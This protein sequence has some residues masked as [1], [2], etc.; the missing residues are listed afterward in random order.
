MAV[1]PDLLSGL[2]SEFSRWHAL[3]A[4]LSEEQLSAPIQANGWSVQDVLAHLHNWQRVSIARLEAAREQREPVYPTWTEGQP[5]DAEENLNNYNERIYRASHELPAPAVYL[6]WKSGFLHFLELAEA[7][8]EA[9][10]LESGKF[11]WMDGYALITV[12]KGTLE[13]HREHYDGLAPRLHL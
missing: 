12:L 2:Q 4:S 3:I 5:P 9:D 11:A 10:L 6:A 8:P 13:H 7:I 1:H